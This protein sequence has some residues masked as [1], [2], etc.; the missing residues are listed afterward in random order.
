DVID[1]VHLSPSL[2]MKVVVPGKKKLGQLSSLIS[3]YERSL[4]V[5]AL[6]DAKGNQSEAARLL[7]T[8]K[9]IIQYKLDKYG[10]DPKRFKPRKP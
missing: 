8:T 5:D 7:G 9:R 10:I 1:S 6:K 3:A 4:I 2:Q